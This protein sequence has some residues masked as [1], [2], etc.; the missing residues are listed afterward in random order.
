M[1]RVVID[2]CVVDQ[3]VDIP[4]AYQAARRAIDPGHLDILYTPVILVELGNAT[5]WQRRAAL[6]HA[7][8]GLG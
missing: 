2:S 7:L 8:E 1:R 6:L 3:F 4:G 5:D